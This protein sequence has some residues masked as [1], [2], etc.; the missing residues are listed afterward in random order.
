MARTNITL[1][2][3]WVQIGSGKLVAN[4]KHGFGK[5]VYFNETAVDSTAY[6]TIASLETQ[7]MQTE[8]KNTFAKGAGVT[9]T[10]DK[11]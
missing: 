4:I 1:T 10:L 9:L 3:T 2:D 6:R 8:A 5:E 11:E 7:I